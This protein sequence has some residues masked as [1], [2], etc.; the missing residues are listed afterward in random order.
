MV[1]Y[2][3]P[4][5]YYPR[6]LSWEV[7]FAI[8]HGDGIVN[9][10]GILELACSGA[11]NEVIYLVVHCLNNRPGQQCEFVR[12]LVKAVVDEDNNPEG[13]KK[14]LVDY[15]NGPLVGP[16]GLNVM[17]PRQLREMTLQRELGEWDRLWRSSAEKIWAPRPVILQGLRCLLGL[18]YFIT[19]QRRHPSYPLYV[20]I[21]E[22]CEDEEMLY[23]GH[24][25]RCDRADVMLLDKLWL[26]LPADP[27]IV[28]DR[29][30]D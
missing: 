17:I 3:Q 25:V 27:F 26:R 14:F 11:L 10:E 8:D 9:K 30:L 28:T 1:T 5:R 29:M 21:E 23:W 22:W 4:A 20:R 12:A 2:M 6:F 18:R 19:A 13:L 24:M 7:R 15:I 16:A